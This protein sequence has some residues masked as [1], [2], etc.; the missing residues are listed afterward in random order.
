VEV[1]RQNAIGSVWELVSY[2]T[3]SW[4]GLFSYLYGSLNRLK[5]SKIVVF[6][7]SWPAK[8]NNEDSG[9]LN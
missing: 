6:N 4:A 8:T 5:V 7:S 1:E 3:C 9:L 2:Y